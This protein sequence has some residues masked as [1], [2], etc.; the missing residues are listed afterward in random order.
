MKFPALEENGL[1]EWLSPVG[2]RYT[3]PKGILYWSG[4]AREEARWNATVGSAAAESRL[5]YDDGDDSL[6]LAHLP[7]LRAEYP[8]LSPGQAFAY[9][10]ILGTKE[11]RAAW[12]TWLL[13]KGRQAGVDVADHT[14]L[15]IV[16]SGI[17][18]AITLA[19]RLFLEIG[20]S[21]IL[22]AK[23][24]GN[25]GAALRM[26]QGLEIDTFPFYDGDEFNLD[27]FVS[28]CESHIRSRGRATAILNF[29]NNPTGYAPPA[30][31]AEEIPGGCCFSS[32]TLTR[33][34][35][36]TRTGCR[37]RSSTAVW[38]CIRASGP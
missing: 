30:S 22:P 32:T 9:A 20:D 36:T 34:T 26:E 33:A 19:C 3:T 21:V 10:P 7:E 31:Y 38:T 35:L 4:R 17:T 28:L 6:V 24:W 2:R 14:T 37:I 5:L 1:L 29:P 16:T 13:Y 15:P 8:N 25:Y 12:R 27:G 11:F 18:H 23:H